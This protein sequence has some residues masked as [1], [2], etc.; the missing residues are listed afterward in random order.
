MK[1]QKI[2]NDCN[3]SPSLT[4]QTMHSHNMQMRL[5]TFKTSLST[6]VLAPTPKMTRT[7]S[8]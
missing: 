8:K 4:I 3:L 6:C 2:I 1:G 7:W 5:N